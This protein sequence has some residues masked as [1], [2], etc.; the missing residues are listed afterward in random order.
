MRKLYFICSNISLPG[1]TERALSTTIKLL[2]SVDNIK[3]TVISL[4]T[5]ENEMPY[6]KLDADIIHCSLEPLKESLMAKFAWY[7]KAIQ[8]L[9]PKFRDL[10]HADAIFSYGHNVSLIMPFISTKA[11]KYACEHINFYS[12]PKVS[13]FCMQL[14]YPF[15]DGV[16]ALSKTAKEKLHRLNKTI[17]IIPNSIPFDVNDTTLKKEK[18]IIMVGRISP[19]KGYDRVVA[20]AKELRNRIPQWKIEI[21]GDGPDY[22]NIRDFY[23]K[24]KVDD[25]LIMKKSTKDITEVYTRASLLIMTSYTEALP[26]VIIEANAFGIPVVAYECEGTIELINEGVN[27]YIVDDND[28]MQFADRIMQVISED[29]VYKTFSNSSLDVSKKFSNDE[30]RKRWIELI[31][32]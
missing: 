2:N 19:E 3:L 27:G 6:F 32:I 11:R 30:I 9:K 31:T 5:S 24:E 23:K 10:T 20:I 29:N 18:T 14:G 25:F 8:T 12:I 22:N 13:R 21:W 1:G 7:K 17:H 15:L 28:Y 4:S 26:M 16:I